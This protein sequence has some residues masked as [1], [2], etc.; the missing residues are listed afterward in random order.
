MPKNSASVSSLLKKSCANAFTPIFRAVYR[1][2]ETTVRY[3]QNLTHFL[4][5]CIVLNTGMSY[6]YIMGHHF[7]VI[8][9]PKEEIQ[10]D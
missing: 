8:K 6:G 4:L 1:V 5:C 10:N 7:F 3:S 2:S 9:T